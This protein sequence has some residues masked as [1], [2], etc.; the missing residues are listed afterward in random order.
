VSSGIGW[1]QFVGRL[2]C[3]KVLDQ[4]GCHRLLGDYALAQEQ[5]GGISYLFSRIMKQLDGE[6]V[7]TEI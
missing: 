7:S 2:V 4:T 6:Q 1:K 5:K 3:V